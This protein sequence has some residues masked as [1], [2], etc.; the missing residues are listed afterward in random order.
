MDG[1]WLEDA[2]HQLDAKKAP[3]IDKVTKELYGERLAENLE[4]LINRVRSQKYRAP[5]VKR[6]EI[7]KPGSNELRPLGIPSNRSRHQKVL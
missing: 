3:G 2:Y 6:V 4:D 1:W 5:A 7:P